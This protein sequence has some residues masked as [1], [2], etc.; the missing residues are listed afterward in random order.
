MSDPRESF[1]EE[2]AQVLGQVTIREIRAPRQVASLTLHEERAQIAVTSEVG[3]QVTVQK[4]VIEEEVQVP[5]T[6]RREVLELTTAPDGGSVK[7]NGEWLEPGQVYQIILTE[8]RPVVAR[9]VYPVQQIEIRKEWISEVK[10]Y[11]LTL[12]REVLDISGPLDLIREQAALEQEQ[13]ATAP[14]L[15]EAE[16]ALTVLNREGEPAEALPPA[17][18]DA[19]RGG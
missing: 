9:E 15:G 19:P 18:D 4:R 10:P 7:L 16:P 6:L 8:E 17:D 11:S 5:V 1:A 13:A 14:V 3:A 2:G 12:G